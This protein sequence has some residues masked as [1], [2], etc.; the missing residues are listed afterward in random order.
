MWTLAW[1][2]V[3]LLMI[4]GVIPRE[5][6]TGVYRFAVIVGLFTGVVSI[7]FRLNQGG[8]WI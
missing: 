6:T 2:I 8:R 5:Y 7:V 1:A 4:T 3:A